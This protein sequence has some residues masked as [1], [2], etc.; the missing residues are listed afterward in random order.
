MRLIDADAPCLQGEIWEQLNDNERANVIA[1][2]Y[3]Q[4]T[5][6]I[7]SVVH[8]YWERENDG[9][10]CSNCGWQGVGDG[11]ESYKRCPECGAYMCEAEYK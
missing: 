11:V 8:A 3:G 10:S 6:N 7:E 4:P 9:C 5:V 2:L 1:F